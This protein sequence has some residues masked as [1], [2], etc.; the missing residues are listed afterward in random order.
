MATEIQMNPLHKQMLDDVFDAFSMLAPGSIV[1]LMHVEG[2]VTRYTASAVELFGLPGEYI[3]NGA[4]DWLE[5]IHPE[6][7]K[8]YLDVMIPLTDG[9]AQTYDLTYRVRI[10]TGEYVNFRLVGA[11]LRGADGKPSLI[12]GAM[13][14]EG[15]TEN[16]DPVTVLP[17]KNAYIDDLNRLMAAGPTFSLEVGVRKFSEINQLHGYTYGNRLLQEM[18]WLIREIVKD[19]AAVYRLSDAA[20]ALLSDTLTR[21]ESAAIYDEIRYRFQ[22]GV[23]LGGIRNVMEAAGGLISTYNADTDAAT[24]FSCLSYAYEES[25]RRLHGELVD[26]NGSINY[27]GTEALELINAVRD[28]VL[29]DCRGFHMEYY[30]VVA[31][32]TEHVNGA[33]ASVYWE[34]E[35]FG[36]VRAEDFIPVLERDFVFEEL[37]DFMLRQGLLDGMRFLEKDPGFLLCIDVYRIQLETDYFVENLLH[38]LKETGFPSRLLSLNFKGDCRSLGVERMRDIIEKLH[39]HD[40]LVIIDNFGSGADS[41]SFLKNAPVDAVCMDG[42]FIQG[43]EEP[44]RDRDIL[45][46]LTRMAATCVEHINIRGVDSERTRDILW[47][48]PFTTLQGSYY[49]EPISAG[50]LLEKY[51]AG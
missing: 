43:I 1:S 28:S 50:Q 2:G 13:F 38:I 19:R 36:H 40:I 33:E 21:E 34:D 18:A 37:G 32:R 26:F 11:V 5:W 14:N 22:R 31:A 45:E 42:Q 25:G 4:M 24:V 51:Y 10:S 9:T 39:R 48:L 20:F 29:D 6:D 23:E 46:H 44:G 47:Q 12:G 15:L 35:R 27:E 3:P 17:N 41:I 16:T 49:S 30:P 7:R 8:R